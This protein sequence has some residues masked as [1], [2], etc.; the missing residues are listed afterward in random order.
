[1]KAECHKLTSFGILELTTRLPKKKPDRQ[2]VSA[3]AEL[4]LLYYHPCTS[5]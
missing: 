1:M 5:V 3:I 2:N 4:E